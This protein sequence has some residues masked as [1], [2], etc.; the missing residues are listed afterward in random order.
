MIK[1]EQE[2]EVAKVVP[3]HNKKGLHLSHIISNIKKNHSQKVNF[4]VDEY[5][6]ENLD[7]SEAET[8]NDMF[9]ND[10]LKEAFIMLIVQPI[11]KE[12][13]L[14]NIQRKGNMFHLL[15]T[16]SSSTHIGNEEQYRNS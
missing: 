3:F 8:L 6:G 12:R 16:K 10:S 4:I 14:N 11:E 7:E 15:K 1:D 13:T 2:S 5:D 9:T